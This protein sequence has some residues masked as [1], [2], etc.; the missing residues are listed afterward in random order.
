MLKLL[1]FLESAQLNI[2]SEIKE[3]KEWRIVAI[4]SGVSKNRFFYTAA[5]LREALNLFDGAPV[6]ANGFGPA[7]R[8]HFDHLPDNIKK[9]FPNG[10][11]GNMVG[12]LSDP[13]LE[14]VE[15][16]VPGRGSV[17]AI[18]ST[19]MISETA[20]WLRTLMKESFSLGKPLGF[21]IDA[22]GFGFPAV[23]EGVPVK[24][25]TSITQLDTLDV[26]SRPS[27]GGRAT[28]L[29]ASEQ[30]GG[31]VMKW[32]QFL[33]SIKESRPTW[34]TGFNLDNIK[35][36]EAKDTA[37]QIIESVK[38]KNMVEL[39]EA[40]STTKVRITENL[41]ALQKIMGMLNDGDVDGA[42]VALKVLV[43][44]AEKPAEQEMT[45]EEKAAKKKKEEEEASAAKAQEAK[46]PGVQ[47]TTP[48]I[49][50]TPAVDGGAIKESVTNVEFNA[51]K[52]QMEENRK[53]LA[54]S[55]SQRILESLVINS[56]LPSVS[57]NRIT[58][59][60]KNKA[61]TKP[62][63]EKAIAAERDY[64]ASLQ[65]SSSNFG[66]RMNR[67]PS[68][69]IGVEQKD[70]WKDAMLGMLQGKT[71]NK[72]RPFTSL[73]ESYRKVSGFSGSP[74]EMAER[75]MPNMAFALPGSPGHEEKF[76]QHHQ[77]LRESVSS[78]PMVIREAL[79]TG[80]WAEV[81]GDSIRRALIA[82]L[83]AP[84]FNQWR[85][86]VSSIVPNQD[87]RTNRR[88]RVGGF[89]TLD[90]VGELGTYSELATPT[91]EEATYAA[92]KRGNL[93]AVS[94]ESIVND[95][96]GKVRDIPSKLGRSAGY[97]LNTFVLNTLFASNPNI[98]DGNA[99]ISAAHNNNQTAALSLATLII[100]IRQMRKQLELSS[101]LR[102]PV[103]PG[104]LV[105]PADLED[106][107]WEILQSNVKVGSTE[108]ET[109][110]NVIKGRFN[111]KLLVNDFHPTGDLNDWFLVADAKRSATIEMGFLGG[112]QEPEVFVQDQPNIGSFLTADKITY[113]IRHVYGGAV[114][115]FRTFAGSIVA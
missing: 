37:L 51:L 81:F 111:I 17:P 94:W 30:Q 36:G 43:D 19:F 96:L 6:H 3:G 85:D 89:A 42:M 74:G 28:R 35:E 20:Q 63:I 91:D 44:S 50:G 83:D 95:D 70:Q 14:L 15:S 23:K 98:Y 11:V 33:Q 53:A 60:F 61:S 86:I 24:Q 67:S 40:D 18:T 101:G 16:V 82:E 57:K 41:E 10:V 64:L 25:L 90:T 34:L 58:E 4:E 72:V 21:S 88:I 114:L 49:G 99:L 108:R 31:T 113:K 84:D 46:R 56:T 110:D 48:T 68:V 77:Q 45:D 27:A 62:E 115:D 104:V 59:M 105:V 12:W 87:F 9:A 112:R 32:F 100:A 97:T 8:E 78:M 65:E 1:K 69:A 52:E 26:V 76:E 55:E 107:A 39:L 93:F 66:S 54:I 106:V 47:A 2:L 7:A 71:I 22:D 79:S 38:E 109:V 5:V 29:V 73:H 75:I 80:D 103:K 13:K 92:Q 102:T